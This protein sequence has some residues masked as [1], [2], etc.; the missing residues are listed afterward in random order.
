[1]LHKAEHD[2]KKQCLLTHYYSYV[3]TYISYAV[4]AWVSTHFTDLKRLHSKQTHALRNVHSKDKFE[5]K[6]HLF[7]QNKIL[8]VHQLN[9]LNNVVF[10]HKISTKT[11][12]SVFHAHFQRPSQSYPTNFSESNFSLTPQN[13]KKSKFRISIRGPLISNNFLTKTEKSF[14]T[15]FLFKSKVKN[16]LLALE[17]EEKYF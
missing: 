17:N 6:T 2:L 14:E 5:H 11:A 9:I 7:R 1:M 4:I 10:I 13:V 15:M 12:L 8:N 3:L 16:K